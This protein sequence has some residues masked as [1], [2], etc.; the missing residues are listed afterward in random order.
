LLTFA[1]LRQLHPKSLLRTYRGAGD[2]KVTVGTPVSTGETH[3]C[4]ILLHRST[5]KSTRKYQLP[6]SVSDPCPGRPAQMSLLSLAGWQT[7]FLGRQ[8]PKQRMQ[9]VRRPSYH[10]WSR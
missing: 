5:C 7:P 4:S 9:T 8:Q 10:S 6:G 1:P 3:G 2:V